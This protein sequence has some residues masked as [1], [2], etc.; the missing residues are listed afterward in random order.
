MKVE[1]L[2][3]LQHLPDLDPI[4]TT[5]SMKPFLR[6][7]KKE[8]NQRESGQAPFYN[9]AMKQIHTIPDCDQEISEKE[10]ESYRTL[11]DLVY[12]SFST[13]MVDEKDYKWAL[14]K[15]FSPVVF[16][17]TSAFYDLCNKELTYLQEGQNNDQW[18][19]DKYLKVIKKVYSFLLKKFYHFSIN[20]KDEI[21]QS[22]YDQAIG[23]TK[24]YKVSFDTQFI[25]V[26]PKGALP[27]LDFSYFR[28]NNDHN[29]GDLLALLMK[30]LPLD[31]FH[32]EGFS[33]VQIQ[34]IT[35]EY[36]LEHI[37]DTIVNLQ[38]GQRII[39]DIIHSLENLLEDASIDVRLFPLLKVN[40]KLIQESLDEEEQYI[41][42]Q[43]SCIQ[44][45]KTQYL[46]AIQEYALH[47]K[48]IHYPDLDKVKDEDSP[49]I[50]FL[51]ETDIQSAA[52][53]P[54]NNH[55]KLVGVLELFSCEKN[56]LTTQKLVPLGP[57]IPLLEQL[58]SSLIDDFNLTINDIIRKKFTALQPSVQWR[59]NEVTWEYLQH[60]QEGQP[61]EIEE[62]AFHE[63]YPLYGSIDVR[64]S[65][66][67][68]NEV[69]Q[70]DMHHRLIRLREILTEMKGEIALGL[71]DELI[72]KTEGWIKQISIYISPNEES[73][74][75]QFLEKEIT[76]FLAYFQKEHHKFNTLIDRYFQD[77]KPEGENY[78]NR[79]KLEKSLRLV[80]SHIGKIL[81][82][83]NSKIQEIYPCFFERFRSD[84]IEY[85][86][87]IGQSITP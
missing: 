54:I 56:I 58:L 4:D 51:K 17:G 57:A 74:L 48:I 53:I 62:V 19:A 77:S 43:C 39:S 40:D 45:N 21:I 13:P 30:K 1:I 72:F 31:H 84:G 60:K 12:Y 9:Y 63:V 86:I 11:F 6:F 28:L 47:P 73:K 16:Y 25:D 82:H 18:A 55:R 8:Y 22:H 23:R 59:F 64:D 41:R 50:S 83:M 68:R 67:Q 49:I 32:F 76:P 52:L 65:T 3:L 7:L 80:N 75:S 70:A 10:I 29:E 38:P 37:K 2:N 5:L 46:E 66:I 79:R 24:Y 87:Y 20:L 85:D 69:L 35:S 42:K 14:A 81:D 71:L 61:A 33:V 78:S 15:P 26:H 36:V 34:D 27:Q 44:F